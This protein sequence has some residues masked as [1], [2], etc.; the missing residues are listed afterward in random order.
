MLIRPRWLIP[1]GVAIASALFLLMIQSSERFQ[2]CIENAQYKEAQT[3]HPKQLS[4]VPITFLMRERCWGDYVD[5]YGNGLIALFTITLAGST[6]GLWFATWQMG[7]RQSAETK[8]LQRAYVTAEPAGISPYI[9]L[10]G[11]LSCDVYF[12]NSGNLPATNI[13]WVITQQ[14]DTNPVRATFPID[15]K[16]FGGHNL[17][18]PKGL[19]KKGGKPAINSAELHD[20]RK[21]QQGIP[22]SCWLY[23]GGASAITMDLETVV[24]LN[25]A[26][27]IIW[28]AIRGLL[29]AIM[30]GSMNGVMGQTSIR[31]NRT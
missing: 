15:P 27:V 12:R 17:I 21:K 13:E 8:I 7:E 11:R 1:L 6:I 25:F 4:D 29:V 31:P 19:I 14:F 5:T 24:S 16:D 30:D 9:S 2:N 28:R 26:S 22:N 10:D 20:F 23:V 3:T 18:P